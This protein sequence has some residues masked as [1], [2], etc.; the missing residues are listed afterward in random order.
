MHLIA[1]GV[2]HDLCHDSLRGDQS[3]TTLPRRLQKKAADNIKAMT[4]VHM[5]TAAQPP[6]AVLKR[7]KEPDSKGSGSSVAKGTREPPTYQINLSLPPELR[8]CKIA[9]DYVGQIHELTT[10]F[11]E[12]IASS[13]LSVSVVRFFCRLLLRRLSN[14]EETA[15]LR[16]ISKAIN[17]DMYLLVAFNTFLDLFM[18]CSSG[19]AKVSDNKGDT[20]ML[21]FRTLD[22]GMDQLRKVVVKLEYVKHGEVIGTSISYVGFVGI[23]TAVRKDLSISLNFRPNRNSSSTWSNIR[24]YSHLLMVLS[25]FKPA[26]PSILRSTFF[27]TPEMPLE[28]R[29]LRLARI[30]STVAY[31]TLS[32][33]NSTVVLEKDLHSAQVT[34]SGTFVAVTNHDTCY[35]DQS[36]SRNVF[37]DQFSREFI[38]ESRERKRKLCS[39]HQKAA[40]KSNGVKDEDVNKWMKTYPVLNEC[41]HFACVMDA[42]EGKVVYL[43]RYLEPVD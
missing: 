21:H 40:R 12:V 32:D 20:K 31:F 10:L 36:V 43:K 37:Q 41:T 17:I 42:K 26:L 38:A 8:Y 22:W 2:G 35:E 19:G 3:K 34:A 1:P 13:G 5:S 23:L 18:G 15:E 6:P 16:G 27:S 14:S 28:E 30:S 25:G 9:R 7:A 24:Y 11:T 33:G 4:T 29:T 39:L